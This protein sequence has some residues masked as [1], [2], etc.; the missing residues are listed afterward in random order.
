MYHYK[1]ITTMKTQ[2]IKYLVVTIILLSFT[3]C[4]ET[5]LDKPPL[6]QLTQQSFPENPE[7]AQL[8]VN[9]MYNVLRKWNYHAGGFPIL[10]IMSEQATKG[11]NPGDAIIVNDWQYFRFDATNNS[12]IRWWNTLYEGIRTTNLVINSI[13][14]IDGLSQDQ[15]DQYVGEARFLRAYHYFTL[16]RAF[17]DVIKVTSIS[18]PE[19]M[20]RSPAEE[21]YQEIIIPDLEFCINTLPAKSEYPASQA[22]RATSGAAAGILAKVYLFREEFDK[23]EDYA[24]QVI[25]SNEYS[26]DP[27]FAEVFHHQNVHG[28]GSLFEIGALSKRYDQGGNQYGNTWGARGTPSLG[29]GFGRPEYDFILHLRNNNDPREDPSILY[30]GETIEG[31]TINGDD[32]TPDTIYADEQETEIQEIECYNQKV[33]VPGSQGIATWGHNRR[34]LRYAD[35]LL[36][37]AEA[38]NENNK[39]SQA[40]TYLNM[41]RE[42]ARGENDSV[43]PDITTT[44]QDELRNAI[45][46]E[47][48]REL[49][50]EGHRY[51]DLVRTGKAS[52]VLG[53]YGFEENKHELLPIPQ[54]EIDISGGK[55][56]QNPGY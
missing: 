46:E 37:A 26:L 43:L 56:S 35:V 22:G 2:L 9:G 7:D 55:L 17:G 39:P 29:W 52:E 28:Q 27:T 45:L 25:N 14:D 41:V 40:L 33:F 15:V 16:V 19:N 38:L 12:L 21:I 13:P 36:M 54:Q 6:G 24:L 20:Q 30:L 42:R 44:N 48:N 51:F 1:N 3:Q 18:P 11:S 50:F 34:I 47:R 23:A 32:A 4:D 5:F 53:S 10:D 49:A 8:A 31:V